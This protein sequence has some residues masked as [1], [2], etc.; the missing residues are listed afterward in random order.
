MILVHSVYNFMLK[1]IGQFGVVYKG[2]LISHQHLDVTHTQEVAVKILKS[3]CG[4]YVCLNEA[5]WQY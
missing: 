3:T 2:H 5:F 4:C 1:L